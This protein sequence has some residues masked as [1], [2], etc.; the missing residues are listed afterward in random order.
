MGV[1]IGFPA[2]LR[3]RARSGNRIFFDP[4]GR[5]CVTPPGIFADSMLQHASVGAAAYLDSF[6]IPRSP[7]RTP[8][9]PAPAPARAH[10]VF[11][12]C[13]TGT[14]SAPFRA[15]REPRIWAI[16]PAR[17]LVSPNEYAD[18]APVA[19]CNTIDYQAVTKEPP[20]NP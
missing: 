8:R 16:N 1:V 14:Q 17:L 7:A 15:R 11:K 18:G 4:G 12:H 9:S 6:Q 2:V 10:S 13:L 19:H 20:I 5:V 3:A